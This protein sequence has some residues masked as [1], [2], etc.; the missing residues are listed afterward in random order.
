MH[1]RFGGRIG[2][3][4]SR[5]D[6]LQGPHGTGLHDRAATARVLHGLRGGLRGK[7]L[8]LKDDAEEAVILGLLDLEKRLRRED[9][10]VVEQHVETFQNKVALVTG[11]A[12]G[13]GKEVATR[14]VTGR[15]QPQRS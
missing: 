2:S 13:I 6:R 11:G 4:G 1:A 7:E 9:A 15:L 3:R 10:S 14:F 12:S 8:A 5:A